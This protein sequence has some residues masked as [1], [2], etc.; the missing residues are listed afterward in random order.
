M[1]Y[2]LAGY[3]VI[4]ANDIDPEMAK[5][6]QGN[7]HPRH[8]ILAPIGNLLSMELPQELYDLDIL[9][10][11]PPCSTFSM[12]GAR[13]KGWKKNKKFREG[14]SEQVLSDL[15]FDW[16]KLV[17]R[18]KPKIA[19][20]ENVK[21]MLN[22][23]AKA[24]TAKVI[25]E[26]NTIGYDVQLFLFNAATMGC[27]QARE[28]VFFICRRM[29]LKLPALKV[30]FNEPQV[31][32]KHIEGVCDPY[33]KPLSEA[34]AKWWYGTPKGKSFSVAHPKGSFFNTC[35]LD[36]NKPLPTITATS[37]AKLTHYLKPCELSD[38]A[39][40]IGGTFPTDYNFM[41]LEA[42]YL[43]GM[44]VP[45]VMMAQIALAIYRQMLK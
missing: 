16:I 36:P 19:V 13:E 45:P 32:F 17:D 4:G 1:G 6:Y 41:D 22:G 7:H 39:I 14:Q 26:L 25:R 9:D 29:D 42:K 31:Q 2:K 8:Y 21:G 35:K 27:P 3:E 30:S 15:F 10:G 18:L 43:V 44:S 23:N 33:G 20:A 37:G 34:Y 5:V 40:C 38:M 24:Y 12:A 28:R 11:S